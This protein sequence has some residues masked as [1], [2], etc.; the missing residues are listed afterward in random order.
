MQ[1]DRKMGCAKKI[2]LTSGI[3]KFKSLFSEVLNVSDAW[4]LT[5]PIVRWNGEKACENDADAVAWR[6]H[7]HGEFF[8]GRWDFAAHPIVSVN[9][10]KAALK[11]FD[12]N[13]EED[14]WN[15]RCE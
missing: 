10:S 4:H 11:A 5:N 1:F 2:Y 14:K 12:E 15:V 3:K 8:A 6:H 9:I 7:V 13:Y